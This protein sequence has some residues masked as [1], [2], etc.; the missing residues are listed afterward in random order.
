MNHCEY[1]DTK[2][3]K[4]DKRVQTVSKL[5]KNVPLAEKDVLICQEC[6]K[7]TKCPDC[8]FITGGDICVY[9]RYSEL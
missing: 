6:Y 7:E 4:L 5:R 8:D 2:G 9:C 1:C 3:D